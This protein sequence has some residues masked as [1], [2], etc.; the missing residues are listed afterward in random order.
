MKKIEQVFREILYQVIEKKNKTLTQSELSKK[1]RFSL[2]T[3]NL[4]LK[5]LEKMNAVKIKKM[6][7][8]VVDVKKILY[9]WASLRNLEKDIIYKTRAE[10]PVREIERSMPDLIYE[11]YSAYKFKF[12]DVPADYSE[13]YVYASEPELEK[14]K[15]RFPEKNANPNLFVLKE[16]ENMAKY[17]KTGTIGQL[18]VELW[19]LKQWYAS[20][21]LKALEE[22]IN[23]INN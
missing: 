7:F 22:K 18:F 6:N 23:N 13:V 17:P 16:D 3:I 1:L 4:A 9:L 12:N 11:A 15:K 10:M 21:F 8:N 5:K 19:N 14:I 2:S 20:D